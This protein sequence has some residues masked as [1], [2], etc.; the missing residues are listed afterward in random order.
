MTRRAIF[1]PISLGVLLWTTANAFSALPTTLTRQ[2]RSQIGSETRRARRWKGHTEGHQE[3]DEINERPVKSRL[4]GIRALQS[5]KQAFRTILAS[6]AASAGVLSSMTA[7]PPPAAQAFDRNFPMELTEIDEQTQSSGIITL[8]GRTNSQQRKRQAEEKKAKENENLV[9][10]NL[11]NDVGPAMVWGGALW[12]L[13]GSRSNPLATPLAN[14]IYGKDSD[15]QWLRDRNAGM[16]ASPP[17]AFLVVLGV[18][19]LGLGTITQLLLLQLAEGDSGVCAQL[20]GVALIG[21]GFF[22]IGRIASGEKRMTR[23]EV[24]RSVELKGEFEEF[25]AKRLIAG[26]NCHR[27]DVVKAFR[28]YHS[29]Y[30]QADSE[31]Y[32]LTDLEIE[33]LLRAWNQIENQNQAEMTSSGFYYGVSLNKDADVFV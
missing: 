9:N 20:A 21:G 11:K 22:E 25:A 6:A 4:Q 10:F 28:R 24:D 3:G 13:S 8:G 15:E 33:K 23:D 19:F 1:G 16:F 32:P 14:L 30:R 2:T 31:E 17:A 12:L 27:S 5:R 29:K 26:G 7:S 18:V